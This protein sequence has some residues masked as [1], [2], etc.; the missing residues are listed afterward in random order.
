MISGHGDLWYWQGLSVLVGTNA[1]CVVDLHKCLDEAVF[2][3]WLSVKTR[4]FS[5]QMLGNFTSF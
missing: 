5:L 1:V 2:A 4:A 3:H